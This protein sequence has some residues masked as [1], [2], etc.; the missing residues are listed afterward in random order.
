M[1]ISHYEG[2]LTTLDVKYDYFVYC[3]INRLHFLNEYLAFLIFVDKVVQYVGQ[4][5]FNTAKMIEIFLLYVYKLY[6]FLY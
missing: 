3:N 6:L 4:N 5:I 2:V 1:R